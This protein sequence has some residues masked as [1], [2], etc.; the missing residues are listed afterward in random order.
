MIGAAATALQGNPIWGYLIWGLPAALGLAS[1]WTQFML[2]TT[3]AELHLRAG[4]CATRS[5]H[6]VIHDRALKWHPL[7]NVK[8]A[9]RKIELSVGWTARVCSQRDWPR[10]EELRSTA[11]QALRAGA[12]T[13][14]I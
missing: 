8:E 11:Q 2:A 13:G 1:I 5:V 3:T 6:D 14:F 12:P 9:P 4:K 7:Y 10:F